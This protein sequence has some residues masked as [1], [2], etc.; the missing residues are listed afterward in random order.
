[1]VSTLFNIYP[2]MHQRYTRIRIDK[3]IEL[4]NWN[5]QW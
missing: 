2:I 3:L 5:L 1:L 4:K